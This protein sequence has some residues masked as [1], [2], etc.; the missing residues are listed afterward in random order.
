MVLGS[1]PLAAGMDPTTIM[2]VPESVLSAGMVELAA[3]AALA[4]SLVATEVTISDERGGRDGGTIS[5]RG[6][7]ALDSALER[8]KPLEDP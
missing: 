1:T 6:P 3:T 4:P 2:M 8:S 7:S 5:R